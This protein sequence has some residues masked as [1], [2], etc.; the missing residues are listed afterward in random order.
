MSYSHVWQTIE[1]GNSIQVP[2]PWPS[3]LT[4]NVVSPLWP[5]FC[6]LHSRFYRALFPEAV[7]RMRGTLRMGLLSY[8]HLAPGGPPPY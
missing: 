4:N 1:I 8:F 5:S 3:Q 6:C 7:L 2:W